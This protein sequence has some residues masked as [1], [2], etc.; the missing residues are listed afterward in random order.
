MRG[1]SDMALSE[2]EMPREA[3]ADRG[4]MADLDPSRVSARPR[5]LGKALFV[6]DDKFWVKGVTYGTFRPG[7]DGVDLPPRE[8]VD[9]DLRNMADAGFNTVRVYTTPPV[10]FLDLA[11]EHGLFVIVGVPWTQHVA[12]L[13]KPGM[14][15][16]I[17][18]DVTDAVRRI[19]AH[20]AILC[21]SIGNEVPAPIVRWHGARAVE[22]F[23]AELAAAV[24]A[25]DPGGLVTYV[26]YPTT[27][28]LDTSFADLLCFNV[29]LERPEALRSY[30]ARLHNIA[31]DRPL[32][33][34]EIGLDSQRNGE[35]QQASSLS[36]QIRMCLEEGCAGAVVFAWTDEWYRG[37][38]DIEDWSFGLTTVDR[39]PKPA[40]SAVR[41]AFATG[42]ARDDVDWPRISVV[43]CS[44]NGSA[45]IRDTM[46]G[47]QALDYPDYEV[48]VV[49]DGSKDATPDIASEYDVRLISTENRGLSNA[50]NTGMETATGEIVAYIDDDAYPD[51]HWL[52]YLA[53]TFRR[54]EHVG[55]GGPNLAPAGD[56]EIADCVA[57][58]PGGPL[59]VL[60]D[61]ET[62][63]HIPGCNMAF[64]R[65]RL[66]EIGGFDARYRAAGDDVDVCWRLQERGGTLGFAHAAVVWHH[67]RNSVSMFWR[68]QKGYGK[69]EALLAEK[70]NSRLNP[71]G[72]ISWG[73]RIYGKG[74]TLPLPFS[75]RRVYQGQWGSAPFQSVY[76]PATNVW[77]ALPLMP[78]WY[79]LIGLLGVTSI[80]GVIWPSLLWAIVPLVPAVAALL[81]QAGRSAAAARF[82]SNPQGRLARLKLRAITAYLHLMQ[83]Y[84]RLIGRIQHGL[85]LW[86]R[87]SGARWQLPRVARDEIWREGWRAPEAVLRD[88]DAILVEDGYAVRQGSEYAGWD[89]MIFGGVLGG[90]RLLT[91]VEEHG[92]GRQMFLARVTPNLSGAAWFVLAIG[93][94][95]GGLALAGGLVGLGVALLVLAGVAA[96]RAV[97]ECGWAVTAMRAAIAK[98]LTPTA[99]TM[100]AANDPS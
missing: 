17:R 42:L 100:G 10:W 88:V 7:P 32:V 14:A 22:R 84:A 11:R 16:Q 66:M 13:D 3:A 27:E 25:E 48:I 1:K 8:T 72:H 62:A 38:A 23:L 83:P 9:A 31:G 64:R 67:R 71:A 59:Q 41:S 97:V 35:V 18:R 5:V 74:L 57:N 90:A 45:T 19:A 60:I 65:D 40:L 70:W 73:G 58:A 75:S 34:A 93:V 39:A 53:L 78:E 87:P 68:Q 77:T 89:Q 54:T 37:G 36:W 69:A 56:G 99:D 81:W 49:N 52:T 26:N 12:F 92:A 79:L 2:A 91:A 50:R 80:L 46:E 98:A 24:R 82:T 85:T 29:Y 94:V 61:D 47:L 4:D 28:Y 86:R 44:Y 96:L 20:P 21:Y 63:E 95:G 76:E 6:G 43:V 51:P 30:L 33:M 15:R 55:V